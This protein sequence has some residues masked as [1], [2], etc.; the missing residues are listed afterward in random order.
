MPDTDGGWK[1]VAYEERN[2]EPAVDVRDS[3]SA[4]L[5]ASGPYRASVPPLIAELE[6]R[7]E[8]ATHAV[9]AD[10]T[11]ELIRFDAELSR[12]DNPLGPLLLRAEC[13]AS[14][15]IERVTAPAQSIVL[16]EIEES[17]EPH[18]RQIVSH[19]RADELALSLAG[20]LGEESIVQVQRTLMA[21]TRPDRR[22]RW[23]D[24][25]VWIGGGSLGPQRASFVP[26][27]QSRMAVLM[28]DLVAFIRR[29]DL[30]SLAQIAVAH[31]QYETVHPFLEVNGRTGRAIMQ[32]ML[33]RAD[34]TRSIVVPVSA[35]LLQDTAGYFNALTRYRAG[36]ADAVVEVFARAAHTAV[37]SSRVLMDDLE[38]VRGS[39]E[40][41]LTSRQG[42]G[43]RRLIA[44]LERQ[45]VI[46][47]KLAVGY[48][49]VTPPNAQLAID[50]L[51]DDGILTQIG[52]NRRNR[53]WAAHDVLDALD[54]F[55]ERARRQR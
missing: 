9:A 3:F 52:S 43:A 42:S 20:S 33:R 49:G 17:L 22:G 53:T 8:P 35:G 6:L 28:S 26:P 23:R 48:L 37:A 14:S 4:H 25:Q 15:A 55:A 51:V 32:A 13:A 7:L 27:H 5:A 12:P 38:A 21:S 46:N 34:I 10:A 40:T 36:R 18:A 1:P 50:R 54:A 44:L 16:A 11:A 31:A 47:S 39:W 30:P 24:Q 2:W 41:R 19:M 45:P 29:D